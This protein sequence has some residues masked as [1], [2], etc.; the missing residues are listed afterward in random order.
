MSFFL[1]LDFV[2]YFFRGLGWVGG[3]WRLRLLTD[4]TI[5]AVHPR[6][7]EFRAEHLRDRQGRAGQ[8]DEEEGVR[9]ALRAVDR[10]AG[11]ASLRSL[12][13]TLSD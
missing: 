7:G 9:R 4:W 6:R 2:F 13:F 8:R 10:F 5:K 3:V 1:V 12:F 11:G